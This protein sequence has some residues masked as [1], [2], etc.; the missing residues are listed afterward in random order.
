MLQ[1]SSYHIGIET[2]FMYVIYALVIYHLLRN[3][4]FDTLLLYKN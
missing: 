2:E 1:R 3:T 4:L